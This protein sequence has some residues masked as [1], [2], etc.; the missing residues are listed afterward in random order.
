[1]Q[2]QPAGVDQLAS[3]L[4]SISRASAPPSRRHWSEAEK[5][6]IVE[7]SL[8]PGVSASSVARHY[9][10]PPHQLFRWR[11]RYQQAPSVQATDVEPHVPV[12]YLL[13]AQGEIRALRRRL[14]E[15]ARETERLRQLMQRR[16]RV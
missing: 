9:G 8:L 1:M 11:K 12:H 10:I 6:F 3:R 16:P 13:Q 14:R 5:R 4:P 2:L 15:T 7:Q